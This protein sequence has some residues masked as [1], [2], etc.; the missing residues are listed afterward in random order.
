M[1]PVSIFNFKLL[2]DVTGE[3][4]KRLNVFY[5]RLNLALFL[6]CIMFPRD[7]RISNPIYCVETHRPRLMILLSLFLLT[8]LNFI[9]DSKKEE[10]WK[11]QTWPWTC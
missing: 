10:Q 8:N 7:H 1:F 2:T 3:L 5:Y 4:T 6:A 11:E 9:L